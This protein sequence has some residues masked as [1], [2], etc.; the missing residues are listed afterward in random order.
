ME[1]YKDTKRNRYWLSVVRGEQPGAPGEVYGL[2]ELADDDLSPDVT[3]W[4]D[5]CGVWADNTELWVLVTPSDEYR[6][7]A[8]FNMLD[9]CEVETEFG[10]VTKSLEES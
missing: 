5:D 4:L 9:H 1:D 10:V 2:S 7:S 8:L 3:E 6:V